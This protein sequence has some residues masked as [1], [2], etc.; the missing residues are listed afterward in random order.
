[1]LV[2]K[3]PMHS[4]TNHLKISINSKVERFGFEILKYL[5]LKIQG[6]QPNFEPR[7]PYRVLLS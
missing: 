4:D 5:K 2:H 1:M 3:E 6:V 7:L